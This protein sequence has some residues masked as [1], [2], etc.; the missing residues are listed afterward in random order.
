M[1]KFLFS[2]IFFLIFIFSAIFFTPINFFAGLFLNQNNNLNIEYAYLEGNILS[3]SVL[4]LYVDGQVIGDYTYETMLS[5]KDI[6]V[7]FISTDE[8]KISGSLIKSFNNFNL[9]NFTVTDFLAEEVISL[10]LIKNIQVK[11]NINELK[12]KNFQC[13]TINGSIFISADSIKEN[14]N[15]DLLCRDGNKISTTLKNDNNKI[16]G[17]IQYFDSSVKVSISTKAL[18]DNRLQLPSDEV[19]FTVDL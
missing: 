1:N 19:S 6:K 15:G 12:I 9:S 13:L 16:L 10:D 18:P 14:L 11:V 17:T 7:K 2:I 3:G 5:T 4:D 8:K